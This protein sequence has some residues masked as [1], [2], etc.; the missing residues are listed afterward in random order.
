MRLAI[1]VRIQDPLDFFRQ[2]LMPPP[3]GA[4]FG[5]GA[6]KRNKESRGGKKDSA[7]ENTKEKKSVHSQH[8]QERKIN[9]E[10]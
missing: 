9:V 7:K 5:V 4:G 2:S 6:G 3:A 1:S 10:S 8:R